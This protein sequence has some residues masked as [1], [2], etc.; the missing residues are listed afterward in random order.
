MKSVEYYFI[1]NLNREEDTINISI[2]NNHFYLHKKLLIEIRDN[3]RFFYSEEFMFNDPTI[4]YWIKTTDCKLN[5]FV[6][7]DIYIK[8][9]N[10]IIFSENHRHRNTK[11]IG[12]Y[13]NNLGAMGDTF[14]AEPVIR[15]LSK[16]YNQKIRVYTYHPKLF[17]NHPCVDSLVQVDTHFAYQNWE[18]IYQK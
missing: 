18:K 13:I 14:L 12:L 15:K 8:Y 5:D 11:K 17:F 16:I 2:G 4:S 1:T 3:G 7:V 9:E 6:S 10:E